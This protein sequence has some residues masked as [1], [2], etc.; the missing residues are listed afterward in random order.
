MA[1]KK[2]RNPE[3]SAEEKAEFTKLARANMKRAYFTALG[4]LGSHDDALEISQE[5]FLRAFVNF[6]K[7]DRSKN[8]FTWYYKILKNLSLNFIRDNK[9][10]KKNKSIDMEIFEADDENNPEKETETKELSALVGRALNELEFE[11]REVIILKEFQNMSYKEIAEMLDIPV[12]TVMSRLYYARK[13]L[14]NKLKG[15]I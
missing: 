13:K 14:A 7:F 11:D 10:K 15:K 9:E 8:F 12:G 5:A 2:L 4:F 3:L 6:K 1:M